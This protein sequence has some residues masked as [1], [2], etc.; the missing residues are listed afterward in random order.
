MISREIQLVETFVIA[1]KRE[2]YA[3]FLSSP[4]RR[5]KFL[6]ELYHFGD[7]VPGGKIELRGPTDTADGLLAELRRRG[8]R[9]D[10][11]VISVDKG[12]DGSTAPLVD[13]VPKVF[14]SVEGTLICCVPGKLAYYEGEGPKN[15][16]ILARGAV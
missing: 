9:G 14:A 10:C 12:L 6:N 1:D 13:V 2:R 11:Y 4:K 15:R 3:G 7:F 8:A 5:K 16:F